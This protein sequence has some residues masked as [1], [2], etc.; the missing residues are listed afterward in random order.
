MIP[1]KLCSIC[2]KSEILCSGCSIK[3]SKG[4]ITQTDINVSRAIH[5]IGLDNAEF[6]P[7]TLPKALPAL[8]QAY[9]QI[10]SFQDRN[11]YSGLIDETV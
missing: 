7:S 1:M 6:L 9:L 10:A 11:P 2:L 3:R 8:V 4:E 5:K